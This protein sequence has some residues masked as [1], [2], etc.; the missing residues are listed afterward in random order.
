MLSTFLSVVLSRHLY[1]RE[2]GGGGQH[3]Q[4]PDHH[5]PVP[6]MAVLSLQLQTLIQLS[7]I[8]SLF[9]SFCAERQTH[10]SL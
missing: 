1:H 10:L 3:R 5:V 9:E 2:T 6:Y 7:Q 8:E 4:A